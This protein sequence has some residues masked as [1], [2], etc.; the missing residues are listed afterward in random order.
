MHIL[1]RLSVSTWALKSW[2]IWGLTSNPIVNAPSRHLFPRPC[3]FACFNLSE[4][5]LGV[6]FPLLC[7]F[8]SP[9]ERTHASSSGMGC[10]RAN[11]GGWAPGAQVWRGLCGLLP[12]LQV[13][14]FS[15][16]PAWY[17]CQRVVMEG[18]FS[19]RLGGPWDV[20]KLECTVC[21]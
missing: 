18:K 17:D 10:G 11:P 21:L 8:L 20:A 15:R 1:L 2:R 16:V 6:T 13:H 12:Q 4:L 7:L 5:T 14:C 19:G 3:I 9:P